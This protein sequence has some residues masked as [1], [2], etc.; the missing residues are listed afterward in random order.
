MD[1]G[2]ALVVVERPANLAMLRKIA[3]ALAE[4]GQ[5]LTGSVVSP[6]LHEGDLAAIG[7]LEDAGL[8][9]TDLATETSTCHGITALGRAVL[10][11]VGEA[12]ATSEAA[13]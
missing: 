3:V 12:A 10:A 1:L 7:A 13:E 2:W 9:D 5:C 11:E 4:D 8:V 6:Y